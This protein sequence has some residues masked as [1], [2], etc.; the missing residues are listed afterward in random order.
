[1]QCVLCASLPVFWASFASNCPCRRR[2]PISS[3][4]EDSKKE[5]SK[6]DPNLPA[7]LTAGGE[8]TKERSA[9]LPTLWVH[10]VYFTNL[11]VYVVE[12]NLYALYFR[13][14]HNW[15]GTW[16]GV[17]Q[18]SGDLFAGILLVLLTTRFCK[19]GMNAWFKRHNLLAN[20]LGPPWCN[21]LLLITHG[22]LLVLLAQPDFTL[23]LCGQ[24]GM[25][26]TFI[27]NEQ[28]LQELL[29]R[30]SSGNHALYRKNLF[31][32][33]VLFCISFLVAGLISAPSYNVFGSTVPFYSCAGLSWLNAFAF[34]CFF[35]TA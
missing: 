22:A 32:Q 30:Y 17:A 8:S 28:V 6:K 24:V 27:L 16:M 9:W 13:Q 35:I 2:K 26:T 33:Y 7:P 11:F 18:M 4:V 31:I 14:V 15:S 12:W 3:E 25:G 29:L 10:S 23:S 20:F 5:D 1:L 19:T 21:V 34:G